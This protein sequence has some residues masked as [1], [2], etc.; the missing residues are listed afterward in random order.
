MVGVAERLPTVKCCT[1]LVACLLDEIGERLARASH[2]GAALHT[3]VFDSLNAAAP[4]RVSELGSP[5]PRTF[6]SEIEESAE[7]E[8]IEAISIGRSLDDDEYADIPLGQPLSWEAALPLLAHFDGIT[9]P[10]ICAWTKSWVIFVS[11]YD[12]ATTVRNLPRNPMKY[13]PYKPGG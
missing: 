9:H 1:T 6:A 12:G 2:E 5:M 8:P 10:P 3:I 7:G 13:H 4:S 11:T